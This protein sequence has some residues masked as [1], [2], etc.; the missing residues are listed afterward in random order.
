MKTPLPTTP[1]TSGVVID[2]RARF[3]DRNFGNGCRVKHSYYGEGEV[4]GAIGWR[5]IVDFEE[6]VTKYPCE[7]THEEQVA[8]GCGADLESI[9]FFQIRTVEVFID[10]LSLAPSA[11]QNLDRVDTQP[12][13]WQ[14]LDT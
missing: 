4:V 6:E 11:R 1:R 3:A 5:R 8:I 13:L 2:A 12:H 9:R 10:A 14:D 7:L